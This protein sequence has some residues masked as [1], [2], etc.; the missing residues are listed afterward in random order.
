[1]KNNFYNAWAERNGKPSMNEKLEAAGVV[2]STGK[3][4]LALEK[5]IIDL[6]GYDRAVIVIRECWKGSPLEAVVIRKLEAAVARLIEDIDFPTAAPDED[7][8]PSRCDLYPW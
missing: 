6:L 4:A 1:M 5:E 8:Q 2:V 3:G 7:T